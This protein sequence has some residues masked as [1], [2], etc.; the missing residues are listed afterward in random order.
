MQILH[1]KLHIVDFVL[2]LPMI[3]FTFVGQETSKDFQKDSKA[4]KLDL[5]KSLSFHEIAADHCF[6]PITVIGFTRSCSTVANV[7][8]WRWIELAQRRICKDTAWPVAIIAIITRAH[9]QTHVDTIGGQKMATAPGYPKLR[10]GVFFQAMRTV[11]GCS[12]TQNSV[13]RRP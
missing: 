3:S 9:T 4:K 8:L 2:L 1:I 10:I 6:H 13:R 11:K 7:A 5:M 12:S